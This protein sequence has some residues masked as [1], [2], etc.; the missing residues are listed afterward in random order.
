MDRLRFIPLGGL[1]EVG[2]NCA[3]LALGDTTIAI[4]CGVGFTNELGADMVHPDFSWLHDEGDR[5]RAIVITHGHEDHIGALPYFLKRQRVPVYAPPYA[6]AL[7]EDRLEEHR[8]D[9]VDLRVNRVGERFDIGPLSIERFGVH[10]S[11]ADATGLIVD[12]PLGTVIHTGDFKIEEAPCEGQRFDRDRLAKAAA[13][14]VRLLLS[15]STGADTSGRS[16][17][18]GEAAATLD[19]CVAEA[20]QRVVVATFSSNVFRLRAAFDIA[21]REGRRVCLLG[22][23]V[24]KHTEVA[25]R[26][27]HLAPL[28]AL[29]VSIEEAATLPRHELMIVAGGTQG[30]GSSSLTRLARDEH[31]H[32]H[33]DP[34]DSVIFS[35]RIIPGNERAVFDVI[36]R[37][38]QRG[39][40]VVTRRAVPGVHASGHGSR[41]EQRAMIELVRPES[42]VP[43]HG[44][45]HHRQRHAELAREAGI[46]DIALLENG[47][48]LEVTEDTMNTSGRVDTGRIYVERTVTVSSEVMAAR[49]RMAAGG[50]VTIVLSMKG[51]RVYQPPRIL[52]HAVVSDSEKEELEAQVARHVHGRLKGRRFQEDE[53]AVHVAVEATR[54]FLYHVRRK[55]P[56]ITAV[57]DGVT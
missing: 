26:L 8:L 45:H 42:F 57:V 14:G 12:T 6:A 2:M 18:E 4:D 44:T 35:S 43:V 32:L 31:S 28:D 1:S 51:G 21:R 5:L 37:F 56:A 54:G 40:D 39:V 22:M 53:R 11:I 17:L 23:S 50:L 34:G 19:S 16:G 29:L 20:A 33:L 30:E 10:H 38:E 13:S 27:G 24:Q 52:T 48:V 49:R 47:D 46:E 41:D 7:I 36:N 25:R 55:R 15:D 3:A 9:D